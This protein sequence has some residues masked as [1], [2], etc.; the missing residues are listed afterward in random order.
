MAQAASP[1]PQATAGWLASSAAHRC[2]ARAG[3]GHREGRC[4]KSRYCSRGPPQAASAP[5]R[6]VRVLR[7]MRRLA[8]VRLRAV[9]QFGTVALCL[10]AGSTNLPER[11][12]T[13]AKASRCLRPVCAVV[14]VASCRVCVW[15]MQGRR[16]AVRRRAFHLSTAR[17]CAQQTNAQTHGS[18]YIKLGSGF[19]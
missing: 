17:Y 18:S 3:S 11:L 8:P 19:P 10:P 15:P 1:R 2:A 7:G 16:Q 4:N 5:P 12:E 14:P 9:A 6:P 13:L